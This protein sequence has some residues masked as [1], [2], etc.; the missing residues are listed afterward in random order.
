MSATMNAFIGGTQASDGTITSPLQGLAGTQAQSAFTSQLSLLQAPTAVTNGMGTATAPGLLGDLPGG[1]T[2]TS[3]PMLLASTS[4]A[5]GQSLSHPALAALV[6]P[7]S[8]MRVNLNPLMADQGVQGVQGD[9]GLLKSLG[10]PVLAQAQ[11]PLAKVGAL[12]SGHLIDPAIHDQLAGSGNPA[13]VA[14]L[15]SIKAQEATAGQAVRQIQPA[16][17]P[18]AGEIAATTQNVKTPPTVKVAVAPVV[19]S[20]QVL[21]ASPAEPATESPGIKNPAIENIGGNEDTVTAPVLAP[22]LQVAA[23]PA[24]V[25][26]SLTPAVPTITAGG[27]PSD[28]EQVNVALQA[29]PSALVPNG[30]SAQPRDTAPLQPQA[31]EAVMPLDDEAMGLAA[32]LLGREGIGA[33]RPLSQ[34]VTAGTPGDADTPVDPTSEMQASVGQAVAAQAGKKPSNIK[35]GPA[36]QVAKIAAEAASLAQNS[37]SK[38]AISLAMLD[39]TGLRPLAQPT[40]LPAQTNFAWTLE[41]LTG[42]EGRSGLEQIATGLGNIGNQPMHA[43]NAAL[44]GGRLP[45]SMTPQISQQVT[46]QVHRAIENGESEFTIRLDPRE[47]GRV[48][49]KLTFATD[50]TLKAAVMADK[51]ETLDLLQRDSRALEKTLQEGNK[52]T[53]ISLDFSLSQHGGE[54]AGRAM[55]EAAQLD[56]LREK[57]A[58]GENAEAALSVG[59][60][61]TDMFTDAETLDAL[62][63]HVSPQTG[64]DV[65]I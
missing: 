25:S 7:A 13:T 62:L 48:T 58:E 2:A 45:S 60:D 39:A 8:E 51:P 27:A 10:Q 47:M 18:A 54:S 16:I 55:A 14:A 35:S 49:V 34:S 57:I 22:E 31:P 21:Q 36:N 33:F 46:M 11:N 43:S 29:A 24:Q 32:P 12:P 28:M 38:H 17:S 9:P 19:P 42:Q 15:Q 61:I 52:G 59:D 50:G 63:H 44:L 56:Q 65:R 53:E 20:A 37:A 41:G 4:L 3:K 1:L 26:V 40:P 64:I 30:L 6:V 23:T 5:S